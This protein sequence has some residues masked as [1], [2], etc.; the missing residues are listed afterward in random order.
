MKLFRFELVNKT[1]ESAL[2]VMPVS[3]RE[4][5][6]PKAFGISGDETAGI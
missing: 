5:S 3:C 1:E 2:P 6:V 4:S